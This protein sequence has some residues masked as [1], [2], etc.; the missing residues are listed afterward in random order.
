MH[1]GS[2]H[3]RT[4]IYIVHLYLYLCLCLCTCSCFNN[5]IGIQKQI[6]SHG[7]KNTHSYTHRQ[8]NQI[9]SLLQTYRNTRMYTRTFTTATHV[10]LSLAS[11]LFL[12]LSSVAYTA[13]TAICIGASVSACVRIH[14]QIQI[15][16]HTRI[17]T[18]TYEY[19][20]TYPS[21]HVLSRMQTYVSAETNF[22]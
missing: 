21:F 1:I 4:C 6:H 16:I 8:P 7:Y 13:G 17:H 15:H 19:I 18:H 9:S 20:P 5:A 11:F 22:M 3:V 10:S 14:I 12:L 2:I